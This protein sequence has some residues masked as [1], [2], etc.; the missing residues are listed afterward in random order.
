M[1]LD[2][3]DGKKSVFDFGDGISIELEDYSNPYSFS[4]STR[5]TI[6]VPDAKNDWRYFRG[7][8]LQDTKPLALKWCIEALRKYQKEQADTLAYARKLAYEKNHNIYLATIAIASCYQEVRN[9][10]S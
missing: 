1:W 8:N 6:I 7:S 9:A 10:N 2:S 4:I 3:K 5:C